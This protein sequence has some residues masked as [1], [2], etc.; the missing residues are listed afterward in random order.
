MKIDASL[1]LNLCFNQLEQKMMD[2]SVQL[3]ALDLLAAKV[4]QLPSI[5][6]GDE[7]QVIKTIEVETYQ[8]QAALQ[9]AINHYSLLFIHDKSEQVSSKSAIRLPGALCFSVSNPR[10]IA[11]V[12]L[13]EE[14]NQLKLKLKLI[15]TK[16]SGV[17]EQKRFEFVHDNLHG[18]ITLNAYRTLTYIQSPSTVRFG[19]ANKKVINKVTKQQIL[20]RLQ[21]SV[22]KGRTPALYEHSQWLEQLNSEIQLISQ[23]SNQDI[24][25][26][27]RPVKVQPIAR[28]W[29]SEQQKQIQYACPIPL[30]V[31][32]IEEEN[33]I[34]IGDL[35]NYDADNINIKHKPKSKAVELLIP[36]LHLYREIPN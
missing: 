36:R 35:K 7:N 19:W 13:I 30:L 5:E 9:K 20:E 18:L 10:Y 21:F 28:V 22:E 4:F 8:D 15:V 6:K 26:I 25:K 31:F 3:K 29:N 17:D 11:L 34:L 33:S 27:Q 24:L 23:L 32:L 12:A 16:E 14:I 2:F 1:E